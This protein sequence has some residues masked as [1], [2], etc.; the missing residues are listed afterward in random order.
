MSEL[1]IPF[2]VHRVTGEVL[3]PEDAPKGRA[4]NCLCPGCKAPLLSRHPKEKRYHFAHD[5]RHK[6]AKPE[7]ECPFNSAVA[8]AMMVRELSGQL[9]GKNLETPTFEVMIRYTCCGIQDCVSVSQGATN[10]I[11]NA[12]ASASAF[13]HHVD[14][15]LQVGGYPI[16]VDLVYKGK[17]PIDLDQG[18]L[19]DNKAALMT[20][21]CDSFS[22]SSLKN[23]RNLRFS[24]A[25]LAFVLREGFREWVFHPKT[26]PVLDRAR[27]NHRCFKYEPGR[28]APEQSRCQTSVLEN[29]KKPPVDVKRASARYRCLMCNVEWLHDFSHGLG[30]P[31]CQSHLFAREIG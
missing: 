22:I 6:N 13:G 21:N 5:S 26:A 27:Q 19:Q 20:L 7:E 24:E 12:Q 2:G 15:L 18:K 10:T 30:C 9:S 29:M 28:F 1:L 3:E 4:C 25:V 16:L 17:L 31:K 14:L 23:D 8:V 11:D